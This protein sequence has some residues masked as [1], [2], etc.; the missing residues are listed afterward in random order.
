MCYD[1]IICLLVYNVQL[2][3]CYFPQFV[4]R[5]EL[6]IRVPYVDSYSSTKNN[7]LWNHDA[8]LTI[9]TAVHG[10]CREEDDIQ[11]N[12]RLAIKRHA[13]EGWVMAYLTSRVSNNKDAC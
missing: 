13:D 10:A 1:E 9:R 7:E 3:H 11:N 6:M 2:Q 8:K 4:Y 12:C 5:K